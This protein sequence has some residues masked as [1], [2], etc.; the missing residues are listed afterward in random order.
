MRL[1]VADAYGSGY[2][3]SDEH[4]RR[5]L[6]AGEWTEVD[7]R[8]TVHA[9]DDGAHVRYREDGRDVDVAAGQT[10]HIEYVNED[11]IDVRSATPAAEEIAAAMEG[12]GTDEDRIY[13]ALETAP[14]DHSREPWIEQ[15]RYVFQDRT[16]RTLD[17]ALNDELSGAEL[18][19]ALD[20]LR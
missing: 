14:H 13:K 20:Y 11:V 16:G 17:E 1:I 9:G 15:L 7:V 10:Y 6:S 18:E 12:L 2:L 3:D 8:D 19:R 4:G 5:D